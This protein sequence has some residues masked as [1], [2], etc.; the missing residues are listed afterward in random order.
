LLLVA[1]PLALM[2]SLSWAIRAGAAAEISG[3]FGEQV[4]PVF[5]MNQMRFSVP[6][7]F[8]VNFLRPLSN[9]THRADNFP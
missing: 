5:Q 4:Q 3:P 8:A 6:F 7:L 2:A 9:S 1:W